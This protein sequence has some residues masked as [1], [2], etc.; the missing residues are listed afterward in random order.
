[1]QVL[2]LIGHVMRVSEPKTEMPIRSLHTSSLKTN[3][4]MRIKVLNLEVPGHAISALK[5]KLR[6]FRQFFYLF[7]HFF[8][9]TKTP[10]SLKL[11]T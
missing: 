1:M 11:E 4:R 9:A 7:K 10:K 5:I 8:V 3:R 6:P 2:G